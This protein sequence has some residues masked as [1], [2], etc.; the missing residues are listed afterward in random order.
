MTYNLRPSWLLLALA[1]AM[2]SSGDELAPEAGYRKNVGQFRVY[3]AVMPA[4]LLAGPGVPQAPGAN[5]YQTPVA[6][7][8]HHVMVS[9]FERRS[10]RRTPDAAVQARVAALGFSGEKKTLRPTSVAG[11]QVYAGPSGSTWNSV[12]PERDAMSKRGSTSPTR[13]SHRPLRPGANARRN[14]E[15]KKRQ[16][17]PT[18]DAE[19][20]VNDLRRR[21]AALGSRRIAGSDYYRYLKRSGAGAVRPTR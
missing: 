9:N 17:M 5:S 15:E 20:I 19:A 8:T 14:G 4:D 16:A 13:V 11:E 1:L 10:G 18:Y 6:R 3:L 7:D 21:A 2:P 12:L